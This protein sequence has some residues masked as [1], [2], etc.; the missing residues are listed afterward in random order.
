M[1]SLTAKPP[2][3]DATKL[4]AK[5]KCYLPNVLQLSTSSTASTTTAVAYNKQQASELTSPQ[6]VNHDLLEKHV[7]GYE[8]L[9]RDL[10]FFS[11][12]I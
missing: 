1:T 2:I 3:P 6:G 12:F 7:G 9:N 10:S 11:S 4:S 8:L 5:G